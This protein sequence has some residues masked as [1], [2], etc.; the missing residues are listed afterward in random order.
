[1]Q[2]NR[3]QFFKI[4]AAGMGASSLA[5]MGFSPTAGAGG[6]ARIQI[7]AQHRNPQHL[8]L[9][10]GKLRPADVQPGRQSQKLRN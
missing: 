7:A 3:R 10:F 5:V 8:P 9:L 2:V 4:C 1:M 6:S